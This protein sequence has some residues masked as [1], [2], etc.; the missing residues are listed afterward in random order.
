MSPRLGLI[1]PTYKTENSQ[2]RE[3]GIFLTTQTALGSCVAGRPISFLDPCIYIE[4]KRQN[5]DII[6]KMTTVMK[7]IQ[8]GNAP[9]ISIHVGLA[10]FLFLF[11]KN[12]KKNNV[13]CL[14]LF[15]YF[16]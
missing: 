16:S 14:H 3:T 6:K 2:Q 5:K 9:E 10:T 12:I 7:R 8:Y 1:K 15:N 4:F 11:F 13:G